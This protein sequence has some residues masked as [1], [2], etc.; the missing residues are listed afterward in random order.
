MGSHSLAP[1]SHLVGPQRAKDRIPTMARTSFSA[2]EAHIVVSTDGYFDVYPTSSRTNGDRPVYRGQL[3]ELG[4]GIRGA[5]D[6]LAVR[7][8][9][10][11][12]A[13]AVATWSAVNG[14]A[15]LGGALGRGR[16]G[17]ESAA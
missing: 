4:P 1:G 9:S 16:D 2:P 3:A 10:V 6:R 8:G 12:L 5:D 15:A 14:A 17:N 13:D 11:A 7:P